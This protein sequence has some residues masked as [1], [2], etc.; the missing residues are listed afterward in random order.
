MQDE[1][2]KQEIEDFH[3]VLTDISQ[4]SPSND[5][6]KFLIDAYVRGAKMGSAEEVEF[7]GSTAVFT[8]R[9]LSLICRSALFV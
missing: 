3:K 4:G 6:R 2:R 8:K 5:V 9:R 7:E 1:S